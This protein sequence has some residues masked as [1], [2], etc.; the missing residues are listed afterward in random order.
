MVRVGNAVPEGSKRV[1]SRFTKEQIEVLEKLYAQCSKPTCHEREKILREQPILE[2]VDIK[3][4][5][6]WFQNRR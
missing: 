4:L 3:Q 2:G 1:K 5:T 6:I